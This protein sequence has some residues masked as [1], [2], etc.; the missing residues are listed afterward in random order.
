MNSKMNE[1]DD[2]D[3]IQVLL[4][5]E[6]KECERVTKD[7]ETKREKRRV[8]HQV[9]WFSPKRQIELGCNSR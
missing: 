1:D 7:K 6:T 4:H 9:Y 5:R 8:H 3:K 2:D